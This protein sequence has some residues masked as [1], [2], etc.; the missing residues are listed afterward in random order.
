M[1]VHLNQSIMEIILSLTQ[2]KPLF[3]F[4]TPWKSEKTYSFLTFSRGI[5]MEHLLEM[6]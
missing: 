6:G 1:L 2:I 3:H 4:Y 5:E